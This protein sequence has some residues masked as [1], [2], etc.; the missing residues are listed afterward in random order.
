MFRLGKCSCSAAVRTSLRAHRH[1]L[2]SVGLAIGLVVLASAAFAQPPDEAARAIAS[3]RAASGASLSVTRSPRS[4]LATFLTTPRGQSIPVPD[5]A[6]FGP[7]NRALSFIDSY[8]QV[9]GLRG[10][11]DV[12]AVRTQ[13]DEIGDEHVRMKQVWSGIPITG[14]EVIL[15]FR[16]R[17]VVAA[18]GR[19]LEP[20]RIQGVALDPAITPEGALNAARAFAA[21]RLN[22]PDAELSTPRLELLN[23]GLL[24]G[25]EFPTRLVWFVEAT[26]LDVREFIWIDALSGT[27][28]LHFSQIASAKNRA[29]YDGNSLAALPG[30]LIRSEGQTP[31]GNATLDDALKAYD[32]SGDTYDFFFNR[33]SRDSYDGAGAQIKST[34]RHCPSSGPCPYEN[35]FWNGS[36]MVYGRN[37]ASADDVV[38]HELTHAVIDN[39]ANLF[40]YMQAGALNESFAD[41]FGE[42]MDQDNAA[43]TDTAGVRWQIGEDLIGVG[44]L[45]NMMDPTAFG[46]PGKMSDPQFR[47]ELDALGGDSGG[48]HHNSGIPNHAF[49]LMSDGGVYNGQ[50]VTGIG[51]AKAARIQYRALTQYLVSASD[52]LDN[53][54]ALQQAC[55][56]LVGVA[57]I[58]VADCGEIKKAIDAAEMANPWACS[59]TQAAVPAFCPA[60]KHAV[61]SFLDN[62]DSGLAN[63]TAAGAS[64]TWFLT[65]SGANPLGGARYA[66][67]GLDSLYGYNQSTAVESMMAL[68]SNLS[69]P[70]EARLQFNHSYGFENDAVGFYDGGFVEFST[71]GGASWSSLAPLRTAGAA[72]GGALFNGSGNVHQGEQAFV[73]DSFGYTASQY[74][75]DSLAGQSQVR[76]RF[77]ISTDSSV[78]DYGWFID[79]F[80][81]YTCVVDSSP[82]TAVTGGASGVTE[83]TATISGTVNPNG[84]LATARFQ[85]GPTSSYGGT[86]PVQTLNSGNT[87]I[88]VSA[89]LSGLSCGATYHYRVVG[90]SV[91]GSGLGGDA[92][93]TTSNSSCSALSI[94]DVSVTEG[95]SGTVTANFQV[96]LSPPSAQTVTVSAVTSNGTATA[97]LDYTATG[98]ATLTF[99]PGE[100][101]KTFAVNVVGDT[102]DETDETFN[103]TLSSPF[104]ATLLDAVGVG[105]ITDDD[106]LPGISIN[107]IL[108][109]EENSGVRN[110]TFTASLSAASAKTVTV[111]Y[112]TQDGTATAGSD[113]AATS[114][115][116]TFSPGEVSRT[117]SVA[118]S[119]D[120]VAEEDET[121]SVV[122]SNPVNATITKSAGAGAILNDD[123]GNST[124]GIAISE[125]AVQEGHTGISLLSFNLTLT[126]ASSA[127]VTVDYVVSPGTATAGVD[128]TAATGRFTFYP[129][130]TAKR[131]AVPL[132]GDV[133]VEPN[134]TFQVTLSNPVNA[135]ILVGAATGTIIDDDPPAAS[136]T[137]VQYRLYS[138]VTKE[139]LYTTDQNEYVVLATRGW[140]QEGIAYKMLTSGT[141]GGVLTVP[142]FRLYHPG[143]L[144]H[145]WTT[146]SNETLFLSGT[147]FWFYEGI[148]GYVV[149]TQ[150]PGT[151]PLYRMSLA[152]PPIHLWTTDLNEYN[153]LETWGWVKEG[154]VGYVVP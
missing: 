66:T 90:T 86:T 49:A 153:T 125:S 64:G 110:F 146:D 133:S 108:A 137:V 97:G 17:G 58:S 44:T 46:D 124:P 63:W 6:A 18:N 22:A 102:T 24:G 50:T 92:T 126:V 55:S 94:G 35:A 130:V 98:P 129:G 123:F 36:Q 14:G 12:S 45:R 75:L 38:G 113:Y 119:G 147:P 74:G 127:S 117:L 142:L 2:F 101:T 107:D 9:F 116:L 32:Y 111:A 30:T 120:I 23:R 148:I 40:Y 25:R 79:D 78:D 152:S 106:P 5:R 88:L 122:L 149:P 89:N 136:S 42:T 13:T 19:T 20:E 144:Q 7:E 83:N 95:A 48:V 128:F 93:F 3:M 4:G 81:L 31:T 151:V 138:D 11:G 71:N 1:W 154:I 39:A 10:R 70:A 51:T 60:G 68:N 150:V 145:H 61:D 100:T 8:G 67:S 73:G 115:S 99:A 52:F 62:F 80:R 112:A 139:H 56:D 96:T 105:T 54:N 103:V 118:V 76:F 104:N 82:P 141:Y 21:K 37:F 26:A 87:P 69:I 135:R 72:Y 59:P 28:S 15:H 85:Y 57:S 84:F 91:N 16:N 27:V 143:I 65:S 134:E 43:G 109:S 34:I 140:V 33:F 121:F 114:N 29:I 132:L 41:I 53:Y 131:L 77:K 47:C